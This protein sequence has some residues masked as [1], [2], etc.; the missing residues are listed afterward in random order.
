M[1]DRDEEL[2][3]RLRHAP[4]RRLFEHWLAKRGTRVAPARADIDPLEIPY[5]LGDLLMLDVEYPAA[6][7]GPV[8]RYRLTGSR[9]V[10]L[11]GY[12]LIGST[13]AA[14]PDAANRAYLEGVYTRAVAE[15]AP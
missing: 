8:F 6:A 11:T 2:R 4:M 13:T 10:L 3:A 12:D 9:I 1:P 15:R 5:A 7:A 14:I